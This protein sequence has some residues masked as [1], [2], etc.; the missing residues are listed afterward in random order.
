MV[1]E[2][3]TGICIVGMMV[4]QTGL[5]IGSYWLLISLAKDLSHD[6]FAINATKWKRFK[7]LQL[8]KELINFIKFE[9]KAKRLTKVSTSSI[10]L[11]SLMKLQ[12]LITFLE[13]F[14]IFLE[15]YEFNITTHFLWTILEICGYLLLIQIE[16]V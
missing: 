3:V 6:L 15:A 10:F 7:R 8:K 1:I 5:I 11:H 9:S 14:R 2:Y 4:S 16:L 13:L 12:L